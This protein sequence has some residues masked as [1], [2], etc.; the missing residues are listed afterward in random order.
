MPR[1]EEIEKVLDNC[2]LKGEVFFTT[3]SLDMTPSNRNEPL[4]NVH[5]YNKAANNEVP[6]TEKFD[7]RKYHDSLKPDL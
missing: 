3:I 7:Y 4:G 5:V 1:S 6:T 2:P